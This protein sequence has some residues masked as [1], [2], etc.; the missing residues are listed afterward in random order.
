[1]EQENK[2]IF[3]DEKKEELNKID[4]EVILIIKA[5]DDLIGLLEKIAPSINDGKVVNEEAFMKVIKP[6]CINVENILPQL[7]EC[8]DNLEYL[9]DERSYVIRQKI[10]KLE[11]ELLP[12]IIEYIRAR[13]KTCK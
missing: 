9:Q 12:P 4:E 2:V 1:M 13:E 7:L 11:D 3:D 5:A 6:L 10:A 8:V